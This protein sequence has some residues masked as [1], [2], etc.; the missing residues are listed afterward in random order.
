MR[1][2][3]S[4]FL[5]L[6]FLAPALPA[7][8]DD[9][10]AVTRRDRSDTGLAR[11]APHAVSRELLVHWKRDR[12]VP[13]R[14]A[15]FRWTAPDGQVGLAAA[16]AFLSAFPELLSAPLARVENR[17]VETTTERASFRF[18]QT[19]RGLEVIGAEVV[20]LTDGEGTV[21][22]LV[23]GSVQVD[24]TASA[25]DIGPLAATRLAWDT[26]LPGGGNDLAIQRAADSG[27]VRQAVLA[28]GGD[29]RLV[30][31][32]V[33][34]MVPLLEKWVVLVDAQTGRVLQKKNEVVR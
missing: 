5:A 27:L 6:L 7:A 11:L 33:V 30:Y 31:R 20:V 34:P 19:W 3:I 17:S 32:V 18:A 22:S 4:L 29:S 12:Q 10:P 2:A 23:D 28:R 13:A 8:A 15:G 24:I 9:G 16:E 14:V 1:L 26:V 25:A 21:L